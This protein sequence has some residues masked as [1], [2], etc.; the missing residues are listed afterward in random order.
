[1]GSR[2]TRILV[3]LAAM[4]VLLVGFA[5]TFWLARASRGGVW[6]DD[7]TLEALSPLREPRL[8][9]H[10]ST[11][12]GLGGPVPYLVFCVVLASMAWLRGRRR[13]AI[14]VPVLFV[15]AELTAQVMK[16]VLAQERA[17][18]ATGFVGDASW[19]SGHSTA[20]MTVAL[21]AVL[22]ARRR[23]RPAVAAVGV[24]FALG[25]GVGL[26]VGVNHYPTDVIGGFLWAGAWWSGLVAVLAAVGEAE[27]HEARPRA[28]DLVVPA[29]L[30]AVAALVVVVVA[31]GAPTQVIDLVADQTLAV[32][33]LIGIVGLACVLGALAVLVA[34][35]A[36]GERL[37]LRRRR[38]PGPAGAG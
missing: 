27:R 17:T 20:A 6:L 23:S 5:I 21:T 7:T 9:E 16:V 13:L 36:D 37:V 15:G 2:R 31:L 26:L 30:A 4:V 28:R 8:M 34:L 19:P 22:V 10:W 14:A 29:G 38:R 3:P 25:V 18:I 24:L 11:V 1:M 12:V 32:A 33:T 35:V